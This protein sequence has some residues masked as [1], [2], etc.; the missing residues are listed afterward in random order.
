MDFSSFFAS[1]G[2]MLPG[3]IGALLLLI[4]ALILAWGLKRLTI[5]GLDKVGFSRRTQSWGMA[6][7]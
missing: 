6:K 7:T 5:K 1:L 2:A 4:L 3:I